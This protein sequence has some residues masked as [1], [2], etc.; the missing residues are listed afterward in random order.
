[1]NL[2]SQ[3]KGHDNEMN[4]L[5]SAIKKNEPS[6]ISFDEI[7]EVTNA[8][9]VAA[10]LVAEYVIAMPLIDII[11]GARPNFMKI[12]PIIKS[13]EIAKIRAILITD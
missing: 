4:A 9:F 10:G 6:P 8:S 12:A 5:V 11:A 7:V 13:L 3:D 2:W 1:M